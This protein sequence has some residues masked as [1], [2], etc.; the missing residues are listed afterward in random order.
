MN[1][2]LLLVDLLGASALLLWGLRTIKTGVMDAF[3]A[4]LRQA[5]AKGTGNRLSAALSGLLVTL[6]VQSST[7]TTL[8]TASFAGRGMI[9]G[10]KAQAVLLGANLGTALTTLVLSF[11]VHWLGGAA[12][13]IGYAIHQRS[14][15]AR[16]MGL[17]SALIGLGLMLVALQLLG[18]VTE[19]LRDSPT[20]VV[21][22]RALEGAPLFALIFAT[23]L[24]FLASSSLATVLFVAA[25]TTT[26][27]ISPQLVLILVAGANVG[28]AIG[29]CFA[30][31][32]D[33]VEGQRL[34]RVNLVIRASGALAVTLAAPWLGPLSATLLPGGAALPVAA[35]LVLNLALLVIFLP[36]L[37]PIDAL[38]C[39][40]MPMPEQPG[41]RPSHLVP[42]SLE[43]PSLA[44]AGAAREAL[45]MGDLVISMLTRNLAAFRADDPSAREALS[46]MDDRLDR[47]LGA[48]KL[49][50]A[51]LGGMGLTEP[52]RQRS[53]EIMTYAINLEHVG[54]ILDR[55][56]S[57][58]IEKK[59][60][61]QVKF[62]EQGEAEIV[63]FFSATI[64]NL[65]LAQS[66]FLTRDLSLARRLAEEKVNVRKFEQE[67]TRLHLA[68]LE[69][70][71]PETL[72]SSALHLDLLRDLKRVNAHVA[73]VANPILAEAGELGESRLLPTPL[74]TTLSA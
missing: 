22:L 25:M 1:S 28:A 53:A 3:G 68:R 69:E 54:D 32:A 67:S 14:K 29:P 57:S 35:H 5:I 12:I 21:I 60:A 58:M 72:V 27:A 41:D 4:S 66:V 33:G 26:G 2:T 46:E 15:L 39:R 23:G 51:R 44:L 40:L 49:Y 11:D 6:A 10:K 30:V 16:G 50:L 61:R 70:G 74:Q 59:T 45:H 19:P 55:D 24:A 43:V 7:A 38:T 20:M 9:T 64:R 47:T 31:G 63:H 42:S 36:L 37:G 73:A 8:I 48:I 62:S 52:E 34:T 13:L 17:G 56:L 18:A 71:R 65:E